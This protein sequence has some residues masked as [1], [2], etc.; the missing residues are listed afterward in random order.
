MVK[1]EQD[2]DI[3]VLD[4]TQVGSRPTTTV[5]TMQCEE[6]VAVLPPEWTTPSMEN[7]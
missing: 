3:M 1:D 5:Q 4:G 2:L 6:F 7:L